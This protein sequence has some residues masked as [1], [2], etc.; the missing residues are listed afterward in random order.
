M[1]NCCSKDCNFSLRNDNSS[2]TM[3]MLVPSGVNGFDTAPFACAGPSRDA[4]LG[5]K[6]E[7][8]WFILSSIPSLLFCLV[9][10]FLSGSSSTS[11]SLPNSSE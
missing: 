9:V 10:Y 11:S 2:W 3:S 5:V 1:F 7:P 8:W 6:R 4:D